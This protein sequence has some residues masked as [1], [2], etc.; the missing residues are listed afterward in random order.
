MKKRNGLV[1]VINQHGKELTCKCD[2]GRVFKTNQSK[3]YKAKSCGCLK[4]SKLRARA[5]I[6]PGQK[7]GF[8]TAAESAG[9]DEF[10]NALW[11]CNCFCGNKI[12]ARSSSLLSGKAK[13]C[14]CVS[15]ALRNETFYANHPELA[16]K[17]LLRIK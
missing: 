2:C 13:S 1:E 17:I 12:K 14:G 15:A 6:I 8:L 4:T 5:K 9:K 7:F 11:N 3:F 10:N 16:Q